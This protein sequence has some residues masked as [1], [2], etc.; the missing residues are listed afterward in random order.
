MR[1]TLGALLGELAELRADG[2]VALAPVLVA[3]D[4]ALRAGREAAEDD[5]EDDWDVVGLSG[6]T[7]LLCVAPKSLGQPQGSY[8]RSFEIQVRHSV[9]HL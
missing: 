3:P 7:A 5:D 8:S 6:M 2:W 4:A 1:D 9:R